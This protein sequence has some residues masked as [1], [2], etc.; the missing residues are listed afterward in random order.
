[1]STAMEIILKENNGIVCITINSRMGSELSPELERIIKEIVAGGKRRVLFDLGSLDY[2]RAPTLRVILKAVKQINQ[3]RGKV[4]LCSLN[5]YVKEIFEDNC[6]QNT[7]AIADSVECG[8]EE[9]LSA[10]KAA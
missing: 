2:L 5:G 1:M 8:I 3:K 4:T 7:F 10:V 6:F 9:L